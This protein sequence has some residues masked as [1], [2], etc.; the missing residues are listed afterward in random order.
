VLQN[1]FRAKIFA[2]GDE[3]VLQGKGPEI[4]L[5]TSVILHLR[6][7]AE[8]RVSLSERDI[9]Y[10]IDKIIR[11][12]E[13]GVTREKEVQV[14]ALKRLVK[15]KSAGQAQYMEAIQDHD[16]VIAIGPAGTG[17][18]Y[19]AVAAAVAALNERQVERIVLCRPAV[20]AGESLG[21]LPGDFKEKIDPYMRPLY[22][23]LYDM[24]SQDK[25]NRYLLN[26]VIEIVPLAYMRGRTLNNAFMILDEAQN[27]T[28]M[29]MKMF[30]TRMGFNS[31]AVVTGDITQIDLAHASESGL[32]DIQAVLQDIE[33]IKFVLLD[34]KDVVR[35]K[36]VHRIIQAYQASSEQPG[37]TGA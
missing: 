23:S 5:I 8:N 16:L 11:Q 27:A 1:S 18:T 4:E 7:Q 2:R 24:M 34:E 15:P 10:A 12:R 26:D 21:F 13:T 29:Q 37:G 6:E 20:E 33:G 30:L 22:D 31:R 9:A 3:I 17:K 36:L 19:L 35:H 25:A 14:M 28:R 32:V